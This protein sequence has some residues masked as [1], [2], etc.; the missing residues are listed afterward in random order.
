MDKNELLVLQRHQ[1]GRI[2]WER[3]TGMQAAMRRGMSTFEG[4]RARFML[5]RADV[6]RAT[7]TP[8]EDGFCHVVDHRGPR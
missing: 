7:I 3:M 8:L 6:I 1:P 5:A 4:A 2:S